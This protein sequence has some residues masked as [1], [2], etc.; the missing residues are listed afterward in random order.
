MQLPQIEVIGIYNSGNLSADMKVSRKRKTTMFEMELPIE[1]GGVSYID[2]ADSP[3][4]KNTL[5]CAKPGQIR[6]TKFPFKC[7]YIHFLV[8]PGYLYDTLM[9]LPNYIKIDKYEIYEQIYKKLCRHFELRTRQEDIMIESLVLEL[10]YLLGKELYKQEQ[11]QLQSMDH[12]MN[13]ILGYIKENLTEDL[14]LARVAGL[15][16]LSPTHF[17]NRFKAA[18]G[19]TLREYVE[20]QRIRKAIHLLQ[21]T[22]MTL[23]QIAFE[24]GFSSQSYFSY[25]FKRKMKATPR[26]YVKM[27]NDMYEK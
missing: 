24:C 8:P 27:I 26:D 9:S 7:Y 3:I 6:H 21:T 15:A 25:A 12:P 14:S 1:E 16:S 18:V 4:T 5:I 22:D 10:I 17:H 19:Q 23:I 13:D 11:K 20:N 2:T